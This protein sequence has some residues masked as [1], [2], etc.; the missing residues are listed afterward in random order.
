MTPTARTLK[1]LR[2]E[3]FAAEVVEKW[4][5]FSRTR[6]DLFGIIDIVAIRPGEIVGIQATSRSN[7]S[8]RVRKAKAEPLL[9]GW[10]DAGGRF[11]VWG[12]GL[13]GPRGKRKTYTLSRTAF[14]QTKPSQSPV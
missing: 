9:Q 4:N 7:V 2:A 3:G 14:P 6:K 11:E 12:W 13:T 1:Q 8:A 10:I 5:A